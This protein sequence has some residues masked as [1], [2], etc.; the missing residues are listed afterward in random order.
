M[1][2]ASAKATDTSAA[3]E[4]GAA[5]EAGAATETGSAATETGTAAATGRQF[6]LLGER[7]WFAVFLVKGEKRRQ[8][9]VEDFLIAEKDFVIL[10]L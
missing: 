6:Y 5:T 4:T 8:A 7:G 9:A 10:N 1:K 2:C 3:T